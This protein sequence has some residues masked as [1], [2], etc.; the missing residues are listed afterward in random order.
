[1]DLV[2]LVLSEQVPR[3]ALFQCL[4]EPIT[5]SDVILVLTTLNELLDFKGTRSRHLLCWRRRRRGSRSRWGGGS[6]TEHSRES[7]TRHMSHCGAHRH[8]SSRGR[9]LSHQSG[10]LRSS[11]GN[12]SGSRSHRGGR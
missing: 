12:C 4:I 9:H 1:M 3:L 8:T 2:L 5:E 11:W 10:L 7:V 6:S